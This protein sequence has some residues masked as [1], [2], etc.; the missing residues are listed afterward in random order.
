MK[1]ASSPDQ[2]H[3]SARAEIVQSC[4]P[5]RIVLVYRVYDTSSHYRSIGVRVMEQTSGFVRTEREMA[6]HLDNGVV[7]L[8][9]V[10]AD[11]TILWANRAD[12]EPLGYTREE[13]VGHHAAE[14]HADHAAP[15]DMW[16]RRVNVATSYNQPTRVRHKNGSLQNV[17]ISSSVLFDDAGNFVHTGC[18]T[19]LAP[20]SSGD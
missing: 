9:W 12:Y 19:V 8:H 11:G 16:P 5:D 7:G 2:D 14:V 20:A 1:H 3:T 18:F 10:A 17:L 15:G 13:W 6:D 4:G